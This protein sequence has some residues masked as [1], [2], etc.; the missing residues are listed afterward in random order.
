[1]IPLSLSCSQSSNSKIL[2]K[3]GSMWRPAHFRS[4]QGVGLEGR[5]LLKNSQNHWQPPPSES[6][7]TQGDGRRL[8]SLLQTCKYSSAGQ[9]VN[10]WVLGQQLPPHTT[11]INFILLRSEVIES[12]K[13]YF[14]FETWLPRT[15]V[16]VGLNSYHC[17]ISLGIRYP[18]TGSDRIYQKCSPLKIW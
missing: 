17:R 11:T 4:D 8:Q 3:I 14:I 5:K 13:K 18:I 7:N 15:H 1:M 16:C 10:C 9:N 12:I 2:G 6:S